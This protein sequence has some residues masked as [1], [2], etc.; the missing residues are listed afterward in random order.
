M[1]EY[2][3]LSFW[4]AIQRSTKVE[5]V[6]ADYVKKKS[7]GSKRTLVRLVQ[8][9]NG[10]GQG[11]LSNEVAKKTQ[12]SLAY[13]EKIR[14]W[15]EEAYP[16]KV[17]QEQGQPAQDRTQTDAER[18]REEASARC[19]KKDHSWLGDERFEGVAYKST[20]QFP[21]EIDY[22]GK[23]RPTSFRLECLFCGYGMMSAM[24]I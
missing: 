12:W 16:K 24:V 5:D 6:I 15:W 4:K 20:P 1:K 21:F 22:L 17:K 14:G 19:A 8:A 3:A 9:Y 11:L 23:V 10:F 18:Y 13:V 2:Q 7:Y